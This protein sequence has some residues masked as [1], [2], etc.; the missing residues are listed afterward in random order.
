MATIQ[1][2]ETIAGVYVVE[3]DTFGD[4]R[5]RFMETFRKEWFPQRSWENVQ[6]NRSDSRQGVLRG[7][8]YHFHQADY[9]YVV[10]GEIRAG[11]LDIRR[12]S[13]THRAS[14]TVMMGGGRQIG[15]FIPTG[16]AH[17]FAALTNVT[18]TYVVDQYYDKG[19]EYGIAWDDPAAAIEWGLEAPVLSSR[20]AD[21]PLLEAIPAQD[22][23]SY[24]EAA[25]P[26]RNG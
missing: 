25:V 18:L 9:W 5:G 19:D 24:R 22:L 21:N 14:E 16:V 4:E 12:E 23:P 20:D 1:E 2:S 15:L 26:G 17:G 13:P 7:L 11:L 8:H 10:Q 6:T 3:L